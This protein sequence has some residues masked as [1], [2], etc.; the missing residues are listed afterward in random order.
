MRRA[1]TSSKS[2]STLS[3]DGSQR[4]VALLL[5]LLV[6]VVYQGTLR[7]GFHYDD[8]HAVVRNPHLSLSNTV[9][10][11]SDPSM[12]SV[13]PESAMYR[14]L[15]LT[16]FSLNR[17]VS[18]DRP[19]SYHLGNVI[20][21]AAN[22]VAVLWLLR[23]VGLTAGACALASVLFAVHPLNSEAVSYVSSRSQLLAT[24]WILLLCS[25]TLCASTTTQRLSGVVCLIMA[26]MSK[27]VAIVSPALALLGWQRTQDHS[28]SGLGQ[29]VANRT[30][31]MWA[32]VVAIV[33]VV[34]LTLIR[35]LFAKAVFDAPV[36][37]RF[38]Q[39]ATQAKALG[40]YLWLTVMPVR[41][42]VEHQFDVSRDIDPVVGLA[43]LFVGSLAIVC[44]QGRGTWRWGSL[45]WLICLLPTTVVP[46]IV[47][48]NEHRLYG[49]GIGA[50]VLI[51]VVFGSLRFKCRPVAAGL[52]AAYTITL[53]LLTVQRVDVWRSESSLWRDAAEKAPASLKAQVRWADVLEAEGESEL[54]EQ[55]YLRALAMRPLHA[56]ARNNLGRLYLVQGRLDEASLQFQ[57]LLDKSPD[58]IPARMN[59]GQIYF[60]QGQMSQARAQYEAALGFDLT[61]GRAQLRI[62]QIGLHQNGSTAEILNWLDRAWEAGE[63]SVDV[64]VSRAIALRRAGRLAE[65]LRAYQSAIAI[66]ADSPDVW[67]NLGNLYVEQT[68]ETAAAQAYVEAIRNAEEG[69]VIRRSAQD[70]LRALKAHQTSP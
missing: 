14:P 23:L 29:S 8:F 32:S 70:R 6:A 24:L 56:A 49:A 13:N 41:L 38:A 18:G 37:D 60:R 10:F 9:N 45:W 47:L 12:F 5:V 16:T 44:I 20:L 25:L 28:P 11:F 33:L 65:A 67:Y 52:I 42:S 22:T 34:Y 64:F 50:V 58:N 59:L 21:H 46:L 7:S 53:A 36:R 39:L 62:A 54:A 40:Y 35:S 57:T 4:R 66:N 3:I 68:N 27:S 55:T 61:Q 31:I 1:E 51:A 63:R 43:A 48:V 19:W 15:L 2:K 26:L 30:R 69:S 17:A